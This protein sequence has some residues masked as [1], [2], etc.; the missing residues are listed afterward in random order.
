MEFSRLSVEIGVPSGNEDTFFVEWEKVF[1]NNEL[2]THLLNGFERPNNSGLPQE[3][4]KHKKMDPP[5]PKK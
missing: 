3:T 1:G 5:P 2:V 4:K